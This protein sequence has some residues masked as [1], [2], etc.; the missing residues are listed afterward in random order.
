MV[1][2]PT[3]LS[4]SNLAGMLLDDSVGHRQS[5]S[6]APLPSRGAVLGGEEWI[7]DALNVFL[8]DAAAGVGNDHSHAIAVGG[9]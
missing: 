1:P 2:W 3:R 6:C 4:T 5:Q 9:A 7:V 8:R